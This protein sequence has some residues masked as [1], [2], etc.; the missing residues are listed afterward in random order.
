MRLE[1]RFHGRFQ[2]VP[3]RCQWP[4]NP[5]VYYILT[6]VGV[7][8]SDH[9]SFVRQNTLPDGF[10]LTGVES[11]FIPRQ[12]FVLYHLLHHF[13]FAVKS[14]KPHN[15][16]VSVHEGHDRLHRYI[17][18]PN[19]SPPPPRPGLTD[20]RV[21]VTSSKEPY[22][23][24]IAAADLR[25]DHRR[26]GL[27]SSISRYA[28][29]KSSALTLTFSP[30]AREKAADEEREEGGAEGDEGVVVAA[31]DVDVMDAFSTES[32]A[33]CSAKEVADR[34]SPANSAPLHPSVF[35]LASC[36]TASQADCSNR[37]VDSNLRR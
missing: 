1:K 36:S 26:L 14:L 3:S 29:C 23:L 35:S 2:S 30:A 24:N 31:V 18:I 7:Y 20:L 6:N 16:A 32:I 13:I 9:P 27:A 10:S 28:F 15:P 4:S 12:T 17:P 37:P 34:T 5:S 25:Q 19:Q 21:T 33:R 11:P 22:L 8:L